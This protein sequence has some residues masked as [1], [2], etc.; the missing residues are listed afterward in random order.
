MR[1]VKN[2][3]LL[4]IHWSAPIALSLFLLLM[5]VVWGW[6]FFMAGKGKLGNIDRPIGFFKELGI[7]MPAFNAWLVAVVETVGGL[8]LLSG[9]GARAASVALIINMAVAYITADREAV[10]ALFAEGDPTKFFNAAPFWFLLTAF[11]VFALGPGM[12]SLDALL[13]RF[14][15]RS[16]KLER[17][18]IS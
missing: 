15:F 10:K 18:R 1:F 17:G 13:K 14:A 11:L 2:A 7:P 8:L 12:F 16:E 3:Y 5:R 9:L 6:A 4:L